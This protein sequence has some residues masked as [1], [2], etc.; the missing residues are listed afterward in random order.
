MIDYSRVINPTV[1]EI[2]PS[3]IRKFF[4]MEIDTFADI[5]ETD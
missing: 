4:D 3:G 2:K 1:A 5:I